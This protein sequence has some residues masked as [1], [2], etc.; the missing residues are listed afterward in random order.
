[1]SN[2][3]RHPQ[4]ARLTPAAQA[5]L[6]ELARL[7]GDGGAAKRLGVSSHN[8]TCLCYSGA[9]RWD[10]VAKVEA[11]VAAYEPEVSR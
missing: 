8:V 9:A 10:S 6:D 7:H 11:A 3:P 4:R 5:K 1:M 2:S